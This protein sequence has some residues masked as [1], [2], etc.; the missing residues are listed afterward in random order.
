MWY[1]LN[2]NT[3]IRVKTPVGDTEYGDAGELVGQGSGGAALVSALNLDSAVNGMF[4]GSEDELCYGKIRFQPLLFQDD[5]AYMTSS[6]QTAEA[7]NI[8]ITNVM[9]S[10]QLELHEDK[11][12]FLIMGEKKKVE[13]IKKEIASNPL[14][15][16]GFITKEREKEKW[17]CEYLHKRWSR[18][19]NQSNSC[20]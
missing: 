5:L 16:G 7:G 11:T 15:V 20:I 12:G 17:L 4:E 3:K 19:F 2:M 13:S 1:K 10:K 18:C 9:Q 14:T 6:R 8:R